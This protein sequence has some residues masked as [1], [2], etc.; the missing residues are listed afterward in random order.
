MFLPIPRPILE[1][2]LRAIDPGIMA[3]RPTSNMADDAAAELAENDDGHTGLKPAED[4]TARPTTTL[5][6]L[7]PQ[8]SAPAL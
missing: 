5:S 6:D 4:L 7:A 1:T 2:P 8:N 3:T